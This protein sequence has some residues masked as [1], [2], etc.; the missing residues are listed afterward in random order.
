MLNLDD[1]PLHNDKFEND[2]AMQHIKTVSNAIVSPISTKITNKMVFRVGIKT[3][4]NT[5]DLKSIL[6]KT[7]EAT[8]DK[9]KNNEEKIY[10][11]TDK[12]GLETYFQ[13]H[14]KVHQKDASSKITRF[15]Y[16][17]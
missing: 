12:K 14:L 2:Y 6:T 11:T 9:L 16:R 13:M 4:K 15:Y 17:K 10:C 3:R 1:L 7:S 5:K 8:Y